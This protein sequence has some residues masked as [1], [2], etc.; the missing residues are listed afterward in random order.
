M[1]SQSQPPSRSADYFQS[2]FSLAGK[3]ALITGS[4][5][6]VG[7][8]YARA[9][10]RAGASIILVLHPGESDGAVAEIRELGAATHV[11]KVDLLDREQ[12]RGLFPRVRAAGLAVDIF[13]N[14]AGIAHREAILAYPEDKWYDIIQVNLSAG[15]VLGRAFAS[16]VVGRGARGKIIN[17]SSVGG[18]LASRNTVAYTA[19]KHGV[20]ALTKS[21]STEFAGRGICVNAI[22]PGYT[23]TELTRGNLEKNGERFLSK[24]PIQRFAQTEDLE[25]AVV[26]LAS[27]ASDY[28][29]GQ[30]LAVDGG[31]IVSDFEADLVTV[32]GAAAAAA[33]AEE[34]ERPAS[35]EQPQSTPR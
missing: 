24:I 21:F 3:T 22:A 13:V 12:V 9:L 6:G 29:S 19:A 1:S 14:N 23:V 25:G 26:F 5:R 16:D 32:D 2:L 18:F 7:F 4:G 34:H 11:F 28:V 15:F 8:A 27:R 31:R 20:N 35:T 10:A 30:V 17:T 33:A